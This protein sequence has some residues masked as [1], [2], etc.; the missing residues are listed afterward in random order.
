MIE[1][2]AVV[3]GVEDELALLEVVR[4]SPCSLCGQTRGCGISLWGRLFGHRSKLFRA[5]NQIGVKLGDSVIVG[6]DE[7][8]LLRS[9]LAAYGAPLLTLLIGALFGNALGGEDAPRDLYAVIGAA[10]GLVLGLLWLK[11]HATGRGLDPRYQ[12]MILRTND[13]GASNPIQ[14]KCDQRGL[15]D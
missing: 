8:A 10:T 11:A 15:N 6:V 3:V 9:S 12:P 4:R 13:T 2:H 7:R 1:E 5:V 14:W